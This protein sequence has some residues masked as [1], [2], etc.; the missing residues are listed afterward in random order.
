[1]QA[2]LLIAF[3]GPTS[4]EEVRPFLANVLRGRPVPPERIEEVVRHYEMIGGRSPLQELT[5]RQAD[6]LHDELRR[7][8]TPLPVYVGRRNW[9]P[10]LTET[11]QQIRDDGFS[12]VLGLILSPQRNE[13][14]WDRCAQNVRDACE[15]IGRNS[16]H[17]D[18]LPPWYSHPLFIEAMASRIDAV[19][20][21]LA[22]RQR[23]KTELVF[24]AHS[25]PTKMAEASGYVQQI[26]TAASAVAER[27]G[28]NSYTLAY[29]SRSGNPREPWLGPDILE[30]VQS[31]ADAGTERLVVAPIGFVCDHVEVLYDLDIEARRA[32]DER[33]I[34]FLRAQT[35]NEHPAFVRMMASLVRDHLQ[36]GRRDRRAN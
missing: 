12:Q 25:I 3:G 1:M 20:A 16:P 27:T 9:H 17:V 6:A 29:Q 24:T 19:L 34:G 23:A 22:P 30:V 26:D 18:L 14:G 5:F 10:Y 35:V 7:E 21:S 15:E 2:V 13:A 36:S 4:M 31:R 32:A 11:L 33:G 28:W 8:G